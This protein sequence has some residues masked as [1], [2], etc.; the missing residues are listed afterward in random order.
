MKQQYP[1]NKAPQLIIE[2]C[3]GPLTVKA[4]DQAIVFVSG[5]Q[6]TV[7]QDE[8]GEVFQVTSQ[9]PLTIIAPVQTELLIRNVAGTAVVKGLH[10]Q[11]TIE[12]AQG[13]INCRSLGT[14]IVKSLS[15]S[16]AAKD[17]DHTVYLGKIHGDVSLRN[18]QDI[19]LQNIRGDF[20][21]HN[22]TGAVQITHSDGDIVLRNVSGDVTVAYCDRDVSLR[23]IAGQAQITAVEGDIRLREALPPGEHR[24][25]AQGDI[26]VRWPGTTPVN[27]QAS[28]RA[29]HNHLPLVAWP[30]TKQANVSQETKTEVDVDIEIKLGFDEAEVEELKKET[31]A[32][33]GEPTLQEEHGR[34]YLRGRLGDGDCNLTLESQADIIL[35]AMSGQDPHETDS[36]NFEF[37]MDFGFV[38]ALEKFGEQMAGLGESIAQ[39]VSTHMAHMSSELEH[40]LGSKY[41]DQMATKAERAIERAMRKT[42]DA[43]KRMQRQS[44]YA[45]PP[46]PPRAPH[47]PQKPQ[48]PSAP[49]AQKTAETAVAQL[50]ILEM[51]QNGQLDVEE[52]NTLLKALE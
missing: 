49:T 41:A 38:H 18:S 36:P 33:A 19:T 48:A 31:Q 5:P 20:M 26:V 52:A 35:R 14:L 7:T 3:A 37:E 29:I 25:Q 4:H 51:L 27:V 22:V 9:G 6:V 17:I 21:A 28:A 11:V 30:T 47:P 8:A 44:A 40:E 34:V 45:S 39:E 16:L 24:L 12:N 46:P 50:K 10:N 2:N 32:G 1:T 15:G 13:N 23:N 43:L 42:E